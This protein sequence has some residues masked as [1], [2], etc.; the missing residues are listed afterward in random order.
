VEHIASIFRVEDKAKDNPAYI[1]LHV[2]VGALLD[3]ILLKT[4]AIYTSEM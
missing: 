4:K 3:L 1:V 2:Y